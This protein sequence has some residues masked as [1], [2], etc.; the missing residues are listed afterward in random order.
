MEKMM[1]SSSPITSELPTRYFH[2]EPHTIPECRW[3]CDDEDG[4]YR[5]YELRYGAKVYLNFFAKTFYTT[6]KMASEGTLLNG[7]KEGIWR[8]Y[9]ENGLLIS[10]GRHNKQNDRWGKWTHYRELEGESRICM[11]VDMRANYE[12]YWCYDMDGK[13][14]FQHSIFNTRAEYE[15]WVFTED[16]YEPTDRK[17][18]EE[19]YYDIS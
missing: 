16:F 10:V 1:F 6:G 2:R 17:W 12:K 4:D 8:F 19:T 15:D 5:L 3:E 7:Y 13:L 9:N 14:W 18:P 11:V